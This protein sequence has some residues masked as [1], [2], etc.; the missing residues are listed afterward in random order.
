MSNRG[1]YKNAKDRRATYLVFLLAAAVRIFWHIY[2]SYTADDAF[3]TFR[4]ADNIANGLGFVYNVGENVMGTST[5]LFALILS[6]LSLTGIKPILGAL[7]VSLISTGL[8]AVIIYRF[9]KLLSFKKY[10]ILPVVIFILFPR[11]ISTDTGGMETP[12]F[13]LLVIAAFYYQR[14]KMPQVALYLSGLAVLT[15]PEGLFL[16]AI[17]FGRNIFS[18]ISKTVKMAV[19][20]LLPVAAWLVFSQIYFGSIIPHSIPAKLALYSQFGTMSFWDSI[21][22]LMGWHNLFGIA[23]FILAL[24]GAHWLYHQ[25][26]FG[27]L[28]LIWMAAMILFYAAGKTH[29]FLW[30]ITPIYP[31]YILI[32]LAAVP[33]L[34]EK[35]EWSRDN[36][37]LSAIIFA[38]LAVVILLY[39]NYRPLESFKNQQTT[40]EEIHKSIGE[41]LKFHAGLNDLIA[42]EDIG[43]IGYYSEKHLLDRDGLVSPQAVPY[44]RDGRYLEFILDYNPDW[45]V[46]SP[47]SEISGFLKDDLFAERYEVVEWFISPSK[48]VYNLYRVTGTSI[49]EITRGD[50]RISKMYLE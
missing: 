49:D 18:N 27:L 6:L 34:C 29:L 10:S 26:R 42:A 7:F 35:F 31:V 17:I 2:T 36:S 4:Y 38:S 44:N 28:E 20:S 37:R 47:Q 39:A 22:F 5:P 50:L 45:V 23:M 12:L 43:Y 16:F 19:I 33:Y 1:N 13:A 32:A 30:Y 9:A 15:R 24:V 3:I 8:T 41:Y 11:I 21:V 46:A 48:L 40:H 14:R 25:K